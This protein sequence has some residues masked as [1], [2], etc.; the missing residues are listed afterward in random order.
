MPA[1]AGIQQETL[2]R[3]I[4]VFWTLASAGVT[5]RFASSR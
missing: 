3:L 5:N 1:N 4:R 2:I